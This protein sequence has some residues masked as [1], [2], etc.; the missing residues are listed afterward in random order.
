MDVP[1]PGGGSSGGGNYSPDYTPMAAPNYG[2]NL[3]IAQ[4][5]VATGYLTGIGSNTIADVEYEI[6]SRTNLLQSDWQSEGFILGSEAT[7][8]TPLSV[9]QAGR[10]NL[11][12]RLRSWVDSDNV[13]IP[14]WWQLEY[15]GS[16]GINPF[17]DPA[18]DG[19]NNLYKYAKG[20]NP[21]N[22]LT[23]PGPSYFVAVLSTNG[24][25]VLLS[26]TPAQGA[27]TNHSIVRY[28]YDDA[29]GNYDPTTV[30]TVSASASSFSDVGA[31]QTPDDL[32]DYYALT[33]DYPGVNTSNTDYADI[34]T[35]ENPPPAPPAA[36]SYNV[37]VSANLIRNATG[38][39]RRLTS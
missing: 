9:W 39:S 7:N 4:T 5:A 12:I 18:G 3:W 27:V 26:W 2:T 6:Q 15:F 37:S 30:G 17:G 25:N 10:Q 16:V 14:D 13:G 33:A 23:P 34:S 35:E 19:Y 11:F 20:L 24:T 21:T 31:V 1:S 36:P 38:R 28:V 8:W 29:T 32:Y 22:F